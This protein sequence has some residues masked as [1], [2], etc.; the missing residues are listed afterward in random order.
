MAEWTDKR[1]STLRKLALAGTTVTCIAEVL[2]VTRKRVYKVARRYCIPVGNSRLAV[3]IAQATAPVPPEPPKLP[4][5]QVVRMVGGM[6]VT[7]PRI[8]SIDGPAP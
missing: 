5:H 4:P 6:A 7:L 3:R 1:I 2:G 8:I